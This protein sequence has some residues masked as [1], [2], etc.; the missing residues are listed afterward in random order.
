MCA[1]QW[2]ILAEGHT[3]P[4]LCRWG[5]CCSEVLSSPPCSPAAPEPPLPRE[6]ASS[7]PLGCGRPWRQQGYGFLRAQSIFRLQKMAKLGVLVVGAGWAQPCGLER[8]SAH[9]CG[10]DGV[11]SE[12]A[13][14]WVSLG[15]GVPWFGCPLAWVPLGVGAP[16]CGCPSF[17]RCCGVLPAPQSPMKTPKPTRGL[18]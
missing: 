13:P 11:S 7:W 14:V 1:F 15:L 5:R 10:G 17:F 18:S 3:L 8:D 16:R 12:G 9:G 2:C 6:E 4:L